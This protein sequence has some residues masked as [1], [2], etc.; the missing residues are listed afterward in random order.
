MFPQPPNKGL[1]KIQLAAQVLREAILRG[2]L[3]PG[4]KL[5]QQD[6]SEQLGMSATP[7]REVLRVLEAEGLLVY[8]PYKGVFVPEVSPAETEEVVP[9]RVALEGLAVRLA[10]PR[11]TEEDISLLETAQTQM[12]QA[13]QG[14]NLAE[15]RRHNYTFHMT[16]YGRCNS[17]ILCQLIQR[18]WPRFA[19][20]ILWMIPG[21][22]ERSLA[23]HRVILQA[24]KDRD[25]ERASALLAEHITTAGKSIA[26]FMKKQEQQRGLAGV[27]GTF[28]GMSPDLPQ[29]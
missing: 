19:T 7:I 12:E 13:W 3:V 17:S 27:A 22:T 29:V 8:V 4:Q 1:T 15:V 26:E 21:R 14:M 5:K 9:I 23:Q 2:D 24:I 28:P 18:V 25:A 20:D 10:V 11:M 6:L 16:I